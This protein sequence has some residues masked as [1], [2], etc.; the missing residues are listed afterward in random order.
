MQNLARIAM[1][2][3]RV[4]SDHE[5]FSQGM[6][7]HCLEKDI[8]HK[9]RAYIIQAMAN[10]AKNIYKRAEIRNRYFPR[11]ELIEDVDKEYIPMKDNQALAK[12]KEESYDFIDA[13][14]HL[15]DEDKVFLK[16]LVACNFVI[17][18]CSNLLNMTYWQTKQKW[19]T[20]RRKLKDEYLD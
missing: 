12:D 4:M 6:I 11:V 5:D 2:K 7:C 3:V 17:L 15:N 20:L 18:D 8:A 14:V 10:Y 19:W 9:P 13:I 1:H 16:V